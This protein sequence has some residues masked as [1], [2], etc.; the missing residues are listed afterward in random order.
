MESFVGDAFTEVFTDYLAAQGE[1]QDATVCFFQSPGARV[2]GYLVDADEGRIDLFGSITSADIPPARVQRVVLT[3]EFTRLGNFL[4]RALDGLHSKLEAASPPY[5]MALEIHSI[6]DNL[7]HIRL[8]ILTDGLTTVETLPESAIRG[9]R[10]TL[11]VWDL[12][13]LFRLV[14]SG[15]G[16]EEIRIDLEQQYG[17]TIPCLQA[18]PMGDYRAYLALVPGELLFRIYDEY[19][20][21]LLERN[22]RSFLQARGK[23]NQGIRDTIKNAPNRFLAYNNGISAIAESVELASGPDGLSIK[24]L[25]GL[26][27][28][29]GGQ[30]TAS[31]HL[32]A[33]RDKFDLSAITV[34]AKIVVVDPDQIEDIVPRISLYANSQNRIS[35]ADFSANDS[36]HIKLE[37]LSRTVWAPSVAGSQHQS[38]WFYE[39][40]RGQYADEQARRQTTARRNA[41]LREYPA[42]QKFTK[43]DVA[44]YENAYEQLPHLVSRGAQKNFVEFTLR[45]DEAQ[46]VPGVPDFHDLV[47]KAILFKTTERVVSRQKFGGYRA[48]I[49]A[50]TVAA[51]SRLFDERL[52]LDLIW[53]TQKLGDEYDRT[54]EELSQVVHSV[55]VNAPNGRNV[56]EWCKTEDCWTQVCA[57]LRARTTVSGSTIHDP[58]ISRPSPRAAAPPRVPTPAATTASGPGKLQG[59]VAL[60]ESIEVGEFRASEPGAGQSIT[61][62]MRLIRQAI[63]TLGRKEGLD[64]EVVRLGN[65]VYVTRLR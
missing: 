19:G 22:V 35:E 59:L 40:A 29:N 44:K 39:R 14:T 20:P 17:L 13:R 10:V 21:R 7:S 34:Q 30:T 55:I 24:K 26:Q 36:Y 33:R 28:V 60:L 46:S 61:T 38:R 64:F 49:V 31:L 4:E 37:E 51:L 12:R 52:S 50:Y 1:I 11:Q 57:R 47:S 8:F 15:H 54:L 3:Q 16:R 32:A 65:A 9:A 18:P 58:T 53:R 56:T 45:M 42:A 2:S 27:I 23:V 41:F 6:R 25:T 5:D 43:T 62:L 63:R 48:N